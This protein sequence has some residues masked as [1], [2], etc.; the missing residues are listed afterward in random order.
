M[1][2]KTADGKDNNVRS[3]VKSF[4]K[5]RNKRKSVLYALVLIAA[6]VISEISGGALINS[7]AASP[8]YGSGQPGGGSEGDKASSVPAMA[9]GNQEYRAFWFSYYDYTDYLDRCGGASADS[10]ASYFNKVC[11]NGKKLGMNRV[12]AHVRPFADALYKSD[13]FPWSE[14]ISGEQGVNPGFDPLKIMVSVAHKNGLKIEAWINPYRVA[15]HTSFSRLSE[16][17]PARIWHNTEG[18]KRNVLVYDGA[19]YFNPSKIDVRN[20]IVKGVREI[21]QKYDVDGIHMDDYFYPSF[22]SGNVSSSFDAY[23]YHKSPQKRK[24]VSIADYRRNMV[25]RLVRRVHRAV[26]SVRPGCTF[27]ISPAGFID[28]LTSPYQYYVDI[29]TWLNSKEYV[30]YICPQIYWGFKH[31]AAQFDKM[32]RQWKVKARS[33]KVRLYLGI[34]VYKAGHDVGAGSAE[35]TEW[36]YDNRILAKMVRYGRVRG[37]RGFAFFDYSDLISDTSRNAVKHLRTVLR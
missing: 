21:V 37:V 23:E 12:I 25:N 4:R 28:N 33:G 19:I 15:Y 29:N 32:V 8:G 27:G 20:L 1:E 2:G 5:R 36:R 3:R 35:R 17:N 24:G 31:P 16:K 11:V 26:K 10:F 30:D 9:Q 34:G 13:Y 7:R 18:K 14:Y 22:S 6:F